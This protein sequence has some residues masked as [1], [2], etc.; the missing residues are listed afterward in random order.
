MKRA[1][2]WLALQDADHPV[3]ALMFRLISRMRYYDD[4]K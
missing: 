2:E 1:W 4:G 3:W